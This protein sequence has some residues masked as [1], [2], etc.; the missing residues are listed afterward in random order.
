MIAHSF[1]I[2]RSFDRREVEK[3][4]TIPFVFSTGDVDRHNSRLNMAGWDLDGFNKNG[5]A[6]FQHD[7][8]G[9]NLMSDPNPDLIIGPARAWLESGVLV[10]T[11]NFE[12]PEINPLAEKIFRKV[13]KGTLKAVSVGFIEIGK[14]YTDKEGVYNFKGQE[15]LEISIVAI[16]SNKNAIKRAI[17]ARSLLDDGIDTARIE[18]IKRRI[19]FYRLKQGS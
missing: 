18:R 12:E 13:L 16:P 19:R 7:V 2:S 14:G 4:R 9:D 3:S 15:L 11:I 6:G 5:I 1:G 10:G 17:D 8:Y